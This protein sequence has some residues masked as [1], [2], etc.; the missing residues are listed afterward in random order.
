M[1]V[2]NAAYYKPLTTTNPGIQR[3]GFS[4]DAE[5]SWYAPVEK[6][7]P[8]KYHKYAQASLIEKLYGI[9]EEEEGNNEGG[10][11]KED[12]VNPEPAPEP[13]PQPEPEPEPTPEPQP[14]EP[15]PTVEP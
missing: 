15:E 5:D 7:T 13:A 8:R 10:D 6:V 4:V 1:N 9:S 11:V 3:E 12:P 14:E 2:S